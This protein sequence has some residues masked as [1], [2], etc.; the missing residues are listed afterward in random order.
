MFLEV[1]LLITLFRIEDDVWIVKVCHQSIDNLTYLLPYNQAHLFSI[2]VD[3]SSL[4]CVM[5]LNNVRFLSHLRCT[6]IEP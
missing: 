2:D 4:D 5:V 6:L 1:K 3:V